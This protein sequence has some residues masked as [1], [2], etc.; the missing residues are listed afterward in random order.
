MEKM[1][2]RAVE[3]GLKEITFT[4]HVD[5]DYPD[6]DGEFF[7]VNFDKY[8]E[9]IEKLK[10]KYPEIEILMGVEIGY[11][12]QVIERIDKLV[13][14]FPFDFV[15]GSIHACDGLD[16][17]TGEFFEGKTKQSSYQG[18]LNNL[19]DCVKN[20]DN[21]DV[22]GHLDVII[23]YGRF[24][25][26]DLE[27]DEF[28]ETLDKILKLIIQKDKGIELNTSGPRYNLDDM[29]PQKDIL[30][31]YH[32]LGGKIL[33]LGSDAHKTKDLGAGFKEA[34]DNLKNIGF[35]KVTKFKKRKPI[36]IPL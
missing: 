13:R 6:M 28:Q 18:Y 8:M 2:R 11:Q 3:L 1:V 19:K 21:C 25:N 12:P 14:S 27:Y 15:M 4:D 22:F 35:T 23:R 7:E 26:N 16:L 34:T 32:D 29:H 20:F 9:E 31:K 17:Y 33:T 30:E 36:F 5:Y 10:S 24:R